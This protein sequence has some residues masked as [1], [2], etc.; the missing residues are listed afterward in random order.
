MEVFEGKGGNAGVGTESAAVVAIYPPTL[1][2]IGE[3]GDA[4]AALLGPKASREA[5]DAASPI[6]YVHRNFPPTLLI[7]GNADD[8]VPIEAS[9]SMY[10]ALAEAG[11]P[12]EL[13]TYDGAPHAF[14]AVPELGRQVTDIIALFLDRKVANPREVTV[15]P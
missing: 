9:F 2:R 5:E 1:L 11:A 7:H 15:A 13:H 10:R 8:I 3:I 12:V 6:T 4:I 14:D